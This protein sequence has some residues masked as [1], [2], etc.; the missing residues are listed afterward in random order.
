[1][2]T[3]K[4]AFEPFTYSGQRYEATVPDT[5]DLAER[6]ELALNGIGGTIDAEMRYNMFF[7][8]YYAFK[9]PY[10]SHHN[11]DITCA[12]KHAEVIHLLRTICGSDR[13]MEIEVGQ[14]ADL[15]SRIQDG[16]YWRVYDP[17]FP[18]SNSYSGSDRAI[19]EDS[20]SPGGATMLRTLLRWRD[21]DG[22]TTVWDDIIHAL[23]KGM[24]RIAIERDDYAYYPNGNVCEPFCYPRSGWP[25]TEEPASEAEGGEGAVTCYQSLPIYGLIRWYA[26]SGDRDALDLATRL[27]RFSMKPKFWGGLVDPHD[28]LKGASS[29]AGPPLPD[30][31]CFAGHEQG[32]W[33]SHFHARDLTLRALLEYAMV[34]GDDRIL[35]F[36]RR[37]YEFTRSLSIPRIGWVNCFPA[38]LNKC[39]GCALGD[40]VDLGIRLSDAGVGD[41]WD[42]VDAVVRNH[43]VEQ[44]L[45]RA[46]LLEQVAA[47]S[48]VRKPEER[49]PHP[50]R[51]SEENVIARSLGIFAGLS[52]PASIPKPWVMQCCTANGSRGLYCAWEGIV[53]QDGDF[54]RINLL[55]NRAA[56]SLDIDSYLPYEGKV[57]IHNKHMRRVAVRIPSWVRRNEIRVDIGGAPRSGVWVGNYL[58]LAGD[59]SPFS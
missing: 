38:R 13:Y 39:E 45:T 34:V 27:A 56:S 54:A 48:P 21:W 11:A 30:P 4:A 23:V 9:T 24:R 7:H 14:R 22:R 43:L 18:W 52:L 58:L 53:R 3:T 20:A 16:L 29:H 28:E 33:Y 44:Q 1:M 31:V 49:S 17:D 41:Y 25:H 37:A 10:L 59:Q 51:E 36:V 8:V 26:V 57:V 5:L 40:M 46:D 50:R 6:A 55:L 19:K 2:K 15:I 32:H 42:D 12:P 47:A 35:E